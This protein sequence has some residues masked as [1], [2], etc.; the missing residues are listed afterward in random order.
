MSSLVPPSCKHRN[1]YLLLPTGTEDNRVPRQ[2]K[3][4]MDWRKDGWRSHQSLNVQ[5]SHHAGP[6]LTYIHLLAS[7]LQYE[8]ITKAFNLLVSCCLFGLRC[9]SSSLAWTWP[10]RKILSLNLKVSFN[11]PSSDHLVMQ[12]TTNT[13][14]ASHSE[15][16]NDQ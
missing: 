13:F 4:Q 14:K 5:H 8:R 11:D 10:P 2:T 9:H 7:L 12:T 16:V 3:N 15:A 6:S 1:T